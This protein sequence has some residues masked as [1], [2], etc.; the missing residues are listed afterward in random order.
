MKQKSEKPTPR[1][2]EVLEYMARGFENK[3]IAKKMF[4]SEHTVHIHQENVYAKLAAKNGK[5]AVHIYTT[6]YYKK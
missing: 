1:E 2:I 6:Q 3:D 5:H 4:I